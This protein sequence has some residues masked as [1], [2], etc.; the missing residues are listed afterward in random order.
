MKVREYFANVFNGMTKG[1][2][3]S[4]IVG[5]IIKQI[6]TLTGIELIERIGQFAQYLLGPCI[7]VG[8]AYVRGCKQFTMLASMVTG[9]IGAGSIKMLTD[10][11]GSTTYSISVGE[12]VGA[13]VAVLIGVEI[14][15]LLEGHTK[16]DLLIIPPIVILSGG[17]FGIFVSPY[18]AAFLNQIGMIINEITRLQPL[19][20]GFLLG[21]IVG[22]ALT[23]PISSAALCISIGIN[24]L[25]AGAALAG[26]SAQMIGFAVMSFRENKFSGLLSQGLGTSKIQFPNIIK[27]PVLW[28]PPLIASAICG[29]LSTMVFKMETNSVG[30]G[31]GTSG[32]VGQFTTFAT[33][34]QK[35]LIPMAILHF[36]IP[37]VVSLVI[38]ELLRKKSII[39][40][41][42]LKL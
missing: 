30:A 4:L 6:G 23:G 26:C 1:L 14:G 37:A 19:P 16:F 22:L 25:A 40:P 32:L 20:M 39:K 2:F 21:I 35:S 10:V 15:R 7:G 12:P 41:G 17:F 9:A 3:A 13:V 29:V 34:G 5:V 36:L 24:G 38:G 31:M 8:I 11:S 33:M 42:D 18:I 27:K 28:V